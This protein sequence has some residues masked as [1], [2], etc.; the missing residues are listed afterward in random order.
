MSTVTRDPKA[1]LAKPLPE[2]SS[3]L[4]KTVITTESS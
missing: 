4:A 2:P 3:Q 1:A